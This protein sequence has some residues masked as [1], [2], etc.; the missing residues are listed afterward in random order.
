MT[1]DSAEKRCAIKGEWLL[2]V[3]AAL[4]ASCGAPGDIGG[5]APT[6]IGSPTGQTPGGQ[7]TGG[8]VR[9]CSGYIDPTRCPPFATGGPFSLSGIVT[10]RTASGAAPLA[11][12]RVSGFAIKTTG[13]GYG[14]AP[15]VTDANGRYEFSNV[16]GGV[17]VLYPGAPHAYQP[18]ADVA[19]VSGTNSVKDLELVDSAVTRP[20]TAANSPIL[21]GV[22]YRKTAAGK[23]PLA[24]AAIEYEYGPVPVTATTTDAQGRYSLCQLPA[25][26]GG[27]NVWLNGVSL[28]GVFVDITGDE[29]LDLVF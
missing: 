20:S 23:Q 10:L 21:S 15:V 9:S 11:N 27:L 26:R 5:R 28:F 7:T 17:V 4:V 12:A 22:V 29:V 25:G 16:P 24:G 13:E 1:F 18:C 2:V 19:T 8:G 6:E 14:I 3:A